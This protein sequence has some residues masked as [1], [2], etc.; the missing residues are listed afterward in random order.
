[1]PFIPFSGVTGDQNPMF[2][3]AEFGVGMFYFASNATLNVLES[4][5]DPRANVLYTV[6]STGT[7]EGGLNGIDQGTIDDEPFTALILTTAWLLN[8]LT[9]IQT[10][11]F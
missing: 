1:M 6:A 11:L 9:E 2:A 10:L 7:A 5:N 4:L 3:R 8:I